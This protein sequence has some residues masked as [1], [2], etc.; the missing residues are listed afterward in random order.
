MHKVEYNT[1]IKKT[2]GADVYGE[3]L[4]EALNE[5]VRGRVSTAHTG[6]VDASGGRRGAGGK[7]C[8]FSLILS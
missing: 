1:G 5:K 4:R 6:H 7:A 8:D 3:G 2:M